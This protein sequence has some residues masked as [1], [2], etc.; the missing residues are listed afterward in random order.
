[1]GRRTLLLIAAILIAAIGTALVWLYVQGADSRA[2]A[3]QQPVTVWVTTR[4]IP[5][6]TPANAV[7]AS[8]A[9]R[10]LVPAAVAH[11]AITDPATAA[12]VTAARLTTG[13]LLQP[14]DFTT[15]AP[16]AVTLTPGHV[17]VDV[18]LQDAPRVSGLLQPGST[19]VLYVTLSTGTGSSAAAAVT[20]TVTYV[21]LPSVT[22]LAV[23]GTGAT[24]TTTGRVTVPATAVTLEVTPDQAQKVIEAQ[25]IGQLYT[26]LLNPGERGVPR[27]YVNGAGPG[28]VTAPVS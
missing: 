16:T 1:M 3:G 6:G 4:D 22:V 23:G 12:G 19:V 26:A 13:T 21:V 10:Q 18:T 17:A 11:A 5:A 14:G 28:A 2:V 24:T 7:F 25:S 8:Y 27:Q 9:S 15:T 20:G